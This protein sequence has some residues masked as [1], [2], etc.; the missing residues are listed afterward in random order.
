MGG[1]MERI[2]AITS[3]GDY[4]F[5]AVFRT[6][7]DQR[8]KI[9]DHPVHVDAQVSDHAYMDNAGVTMEVGTT[10]VLVGGGESATVY[11]ILLDLQEKREPMTLVTRLK[12]YDNMVVESIS[13]SDDFSMMG[14]LK[15]SIKLKEVKLVDTLDVEV[16][17]KG[18]SRYP[19]KTDST[20]GGEVQA[21]PGSDEGKVIIREEFVDEANSP[22]EAAGMAADAAYREVLRRGGTRE[23]AA[24]MCNAVAAAAYRG[25]PVLTADEQTEFDKMSEL[26]PRSNAFWTTP[27]AVFGGLT[28]MQVYTFP[29]KQVDSGLSPKKHRSSLNFGKPRPNS[30]PPYTRSHAA[31]DIYPTGSSTAKEGVKISAIIGGTVIYVGPF[32]SGTDQVVVRNIDGSIVRYGELSP[33]VKEKAFVKQGDAVGKTKKMDGGSTMLHIEMY[34]GGLGY[35]LRGDNK[36]SLTDESNTGPNANPF[37]AARRST[38][39]VKSGKKE[40]LPF[41]RRD[42]LIDDSPIGMLNPYR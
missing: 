18:K 26:S 39:V 19:H 25:M 10:D 6:N 21:I 31:I 11:Q 24:D 40:I 5:D 28:R 14:R 23:E 36:I 4:F 1:F 9:T 20:D 7:H 37:V 15:A 35:T 27:D 16:R 3:L 33:L 30:G 32:Y 41:G 17:K 38:G 22:G 13:V 29:Y 42:D 12:S 8:A 34:T 2:Y